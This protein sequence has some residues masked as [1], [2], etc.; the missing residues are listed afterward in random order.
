MNKRTLAFG[1]VAV[2]FAL[3]LATQRLAHT[4]L[5]TSSA[6][7]TPAVALDGYVRV[8]RV[9]DG[10]TIELTDGRKVRYLG[11]DTPETVNPKKPVQCYGHEASAYNTSLVDAKEVKLVA[12]VQDTDQYGRLLRYVYLPDGT[13]VNLALVQGGY[14]RA[15][16]WP[17][18]IAHAKE[19][20]T[21]QNAAR[22][23]GVGLW[24]ACPSP[25]D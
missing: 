9:V 21:A 8:A 2:L 15:Y 14:A 13:F 11:M 22:I 19:F 3:G 20:L 17:P 18:N 24:S 16:A 4:P 10:D 23:S 6:S 12:D 1:L 25:K 7:P 5:P